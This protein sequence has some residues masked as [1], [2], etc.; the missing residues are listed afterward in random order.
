VRVDYNV[1][2]K[3]GKVGDDTVSAAMPTLQY[4]LDHAR[5]DPLSHLGR[6]KG[7]PIQNTRCDRRRLSERLAGQTG[8]VLCRAAGPAA[9]EAAKALKP[10]ESCC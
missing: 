3:E 10:G 7:G 9:Q 5:C 2:I 8:E 1:P 6:P 4:L